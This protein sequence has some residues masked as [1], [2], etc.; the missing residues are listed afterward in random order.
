MVISQPGGS[1]SDTT[2]INGYDSTTLT[3]KDCTAN[4][5]GICNV[6][7]MLLSKYFIDADPVDSQ[8][9]GV[10]VLA[11]NFNRRL[12]TIPIISSLRDAVSTDRKL[13]EDGTSAFEMQVQLAPT[14][15]RALR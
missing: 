14:Q 15:N 8:A 6:N 5:D 3:T 11:F 2:A 7:T 1:G 10:A 12:V 4:N 9:T 13:D